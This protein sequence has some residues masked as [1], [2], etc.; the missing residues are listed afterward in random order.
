MASKEYNEIYSSDEDAPK[1]KKKPKIMKLPNRMI[2]IKNAEKDKGN[3]MEKW[4][5][6]KNRS[7]G[8]IIHPFRLLAL[9][10]V[11]RGKTNSCKNIFL[12]HQSSAKKFK[13]LYIITCSEDSREWLDCEPNAVLTD[14]PDLDMFDGVEKTC[15]ILDDFETMKMSKDQ[16][17]KLST[18]MRF[19][20]SHRNVSCILSYQ[21]FFDTPGICRK[22]ANAF[23][24]YKPNSRQEM[25]SIAN[26]VG[27]DG[28]KM[29]HLFKHEITGTYD[30]LFVDKTIGTPYSLRK[31][32]YEIIEEVDSSDED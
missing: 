12:R 9:G 27:I 25:H 13:Q 11:G 31:N 2:V 10:G 16:L 23:M 5:K 21:S 32:I 1:K 15:V 26:R 29:K 7:P 28:D 8:H 19:V 30:H 18:L 17:R 22:V 4:D 20:S 14:I 3:W 24:I 6:P